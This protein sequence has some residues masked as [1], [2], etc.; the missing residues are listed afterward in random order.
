MKEL[1][2]QAASS[3]L[4]VLFGHVASGGQCPFLGVKQICRSGGPTSVF[5]PERTFGRHRPR[6]V[7]ERFWDC[8]SVPMVLAVLACFGP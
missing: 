3:R 8:Q 4:L 7:R 2:R 5:D 1:A 6:G